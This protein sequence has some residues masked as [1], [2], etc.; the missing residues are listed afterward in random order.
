M[1]STPSP[2]PGRCMQFP[3]PLKRFDHFMKLSFLILL[4]AFCST[5]QSQAQN[6]NN[7]SENSFSRLTFH[8]T[9]CFGSCP[10]ISMNLY[11]DKRI[12]VS[13]TIYK[14]RY[15]GKVDSTLTGNYKGYLT[16][17]ELKKIT[18]LFKKINWDTLVFPKIFCCDA[19][20]K[21]IIISTKGKLRK[22]KSMQPPKETKELFS[23]LIDI[24][25]KRSLT[26]HDKTFHFDDF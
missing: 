17:K 6:V 21:T 13:R 5:F 20:I 1:N 15:K 4:I 23:S 14:P 25:S 8:S 16:D 24:A 12:E 7:N 22:F 19:P 2:S 3:R 10:A 26:K 18:D 9:A 11:S